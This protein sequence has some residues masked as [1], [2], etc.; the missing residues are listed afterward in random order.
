M[1]KIIAH[2]LQIEF[3]TLTGIK[4]KCRYLY[5]GSKHIPSTL[6]KGEKGVYV[7]INGKKCFKVGQAG[8]KSQA[9]WKYQHYHIDAKTTS[10][11][12]KSIFK[13]KDRFKKYYPKEKHKEI[14]CL[15]KRNMEAWI[16]NNV[17]RIEF[18]ISEE[19]SQT[20]LNLLEAII[21]YKLNPV[22]EGKIVN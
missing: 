3:T 2:K 17:T 18:I 22:F 10:T 6:K 8:T 5:K 20:S 19:E 16:K 11:F 13:N 1:S 15:N 7:F 14:E 12:A 9:R 21:Q 4:C